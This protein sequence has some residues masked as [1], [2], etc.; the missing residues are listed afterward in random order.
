MTIEN[1]PENQQ[2]DWTYDPAPQSIEHVDIHDSYEL[3]I[4]GKFT[5]SKDGSYRDSINPATEKILAKVAEA[6]VEGETVGA[7]AIAPEVSVRARCTVAEAGEGE[8]VG[9]AEAGAPEVRVTDASCAVA[10]AEVGV[11]DETVGVAA[12]AAP[13]NN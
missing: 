3:F 9:A 7:A 13:L 8:T 1:H 12:A 5:S 6:G 2:A 11:D 10:E 4:N